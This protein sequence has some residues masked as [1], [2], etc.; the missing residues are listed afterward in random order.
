MLILILVLHIGFENEPQIN[1]MNYVWDCFNHI[2]KSEKYKKIQYLDIESQ[3]EIFN[4]IL[5]IID[6]QIFK[7]FDDESDDDELND[8]E[9]K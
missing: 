2:L 6:T 9:L 5:Y 7:N 4:T 8:D 3:D 1:F